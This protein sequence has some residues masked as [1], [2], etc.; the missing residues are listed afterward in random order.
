MLRQTL[1]E[2]HPEQHDGDNTRTRKTTVPAQEEVNHTFT[3][4]HCAPFARYGAGGLGYHQSSGEHLRFVM[5]GAAG[6]SALI[7]VTV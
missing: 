5:S 1:A 6:S 2:P 4:Y 3:G 7:F